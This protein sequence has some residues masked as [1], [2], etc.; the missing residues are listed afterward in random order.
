MG[1]MD[2]VARKIRSR[3]LAMDRLNEL[4]AMIA[5]GALA[6]LGLFGVIAATTVPGKAST[7]AGQDPTAGVSAGT[8]TS[9]SGT[10]FSHHHRQDSGGTISASS[11]PPIV[12]S[13]GSH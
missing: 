7:S 4:T 10:S 1:N 5:V 2:S 8:S 3:D 13:G 12:V 11:G 9:G 6:A